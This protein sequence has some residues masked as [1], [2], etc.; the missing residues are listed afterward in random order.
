MTSREKKEKKNNK[1][2]CS[3]VQISPEASVI[4]IF[5]VM[6]DLFLTFLAWHTL[7]I[8]APVANPF[9]LSWDEGTQPPQVPASLYLP[10]S[11]QGL[12]CPSAPHKPR[13]SP[14]AGVY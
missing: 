4:I 8:T 10:G 9:Q 12:G 5:P 3:A 1:S 13:A 11:P 6:S 2:C 14:L 7:Q